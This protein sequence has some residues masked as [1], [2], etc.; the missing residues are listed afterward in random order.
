MPQAKNYT[1][2]ASRRRRQLL[3][4]AF[5]IALTVVLQAGLAAG[6]Y[7]WLG[8]DGKVHYG[9]K[10]PSKE[11]STPIEIKS[12]PAPRPEDGERRVKTQRLLG[13]LES[14]REREKQEAAQASAEQALQ[15][16]NCQSAR[17]QL[18]L[19]QRANGIFRPGPEGE[20]IYLS[21]EERGQ[22]LAR[23]RA[24]IGEW[25]K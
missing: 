23:A 18:D 1:L 6:I 10:P 20:R 2:E 11:D 19:Y 22:A 14:Q 9:D 24:V 25:C 3:A 13:A 7:R 17:R 8:E 21:D 15:Q 16:S 12:A 4:L 5:G